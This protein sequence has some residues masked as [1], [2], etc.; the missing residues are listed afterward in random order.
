MRILKIGYYQFEVPND[1][2]VGEV[3]ETLSK[4]KALDYIYRN[5]TSVLYYK[6]Q[7]DISIIHCSEH[8]ASSQEDAI[9]YA[10]SLPKE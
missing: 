10:E 2:N 3:I 7:E 9:K 5:R 1:V 6:V 8:I 4:L